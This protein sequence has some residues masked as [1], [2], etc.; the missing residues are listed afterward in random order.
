MPEQF[1]LRP[2]PKLSDIPEF[3][4]SIDELI[5]Q[6]EAIKKKLSIDYFYYDNNIPSNFKDLPEYLGEI[7]LNKNP[8]LEKKLTSLTLK[9]N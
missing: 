3:D 9:R 5:N 2:L 4:Y 7:K 8:V 6:L 1:D